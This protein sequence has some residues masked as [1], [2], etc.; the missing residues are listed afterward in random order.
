VRRAVSLLRP[1]ALAI[2]ATARLWRLSAR[3]EVLGPARRVTDATA[4]RVARAAQLASSR[5]HVGVPPLYVS[6]GLP[7]ASGAFGTDDE[8][9]I[10]LHAALENELDDAELVFVLGGELARVQNRHVQLFT[11]AAFLDRAEPGSLRARATGPA[12][13]ALEGWRRRGQISVDRGGLVAGRDLDAAARAIEKTA[14][15]A[16]PVDV[17]EGAPDDAEGAGLPDDAVRA[18]ALRLDALRVFSRGAYYRSLVGGPGETGGLSARD[19][20]AQV[21]ALLRGKPPAPDRADSTDDDGG[22]R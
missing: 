14:R 4:P 17:E 18:R 5:M 9:Q 20:D 8:P 7:V 11:A 16:E 3:A 10:V 6:P 12:R 2:S 19:V 13:S 22:D 15:I 1:V 21:T